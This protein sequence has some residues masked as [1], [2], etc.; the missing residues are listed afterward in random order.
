L[1]IFEGLIHP[2][3]GSIRRTGRILGKIEPALS[4]RTR[5][6]PLYPPDGYIG[7]QSL[8]CLHRK[9]AGSLSRFTLFWSDIVIENAFS[10]AAG[11]Y[12]GSA[13]HRCVPIH[14]RLIPLIRSMF[15]RH[16]KGIKKGSRPARDLLIPAGHSLIYSVARSGVGVIFGP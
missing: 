4:S 3:G 2:H 14:C 8:P 5:L 13:A 9:T 1:N 11:A 16:F 10:S 12:S 7:P 6:A 15:Q